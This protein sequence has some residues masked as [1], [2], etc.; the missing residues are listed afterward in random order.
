EQT[1]WRAGDVV[2]KPVQEPNPGEAD[3]VAGVLDAVDEDGF[4]VIK[5]VR[6]VDGGWLEDG[7]TAWCWFNGHHERARWR[8]VVAAADAF[9]AAVPKAIAQ[10]GVAAHPDWLDT[11]EHRWARAEATVWHGAALPPTVNHGAVEWRLFERAIALGPPLTDDERA[12]AIVVHGDI[13]SNVL[14]LADTSAHAFIDVSPGWR[15]A[16]STR[17]QIAVEAVT[18]F[19]APIEL[20]AEFPPADVARAA[21]FRLLCGL[22]A[23]ADWATDFPGEIEAW[24]RALDAIGA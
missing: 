21:A 19:G 12:G 17:A 10:A 15:P 6:S 5:P 1:A 9:H 20:L 3:W 22:Q 24:T 8:E 23:S 13:A 14:R 16:A 18:W 2:L 7:W 11:R 4:R